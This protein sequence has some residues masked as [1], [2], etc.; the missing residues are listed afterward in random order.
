MTI[1]PNVS[2]VSLNEI[3][4]ALREVRHPIDVAVWS[5]ENYFNFGSIVRVSHNFLVRKIYAVDIADY[6]RKA[7]MGTRKYEDIEKVSLES[8]LALTEGRN[9]VAFERRADL[10]SRDLRGF[11]WPKEPIAFFGS[12]KTGVPDIILERAHSIVSI[13]MFGMHNDQNV[14]VATGIGL[15]DFVTKHYLGGSV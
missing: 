1:G 2:D 10:A 12:E 8:F 5:I 3:R 6:Y 13:P 4:D 7:D 14:A 15:Y 9:I 11:V